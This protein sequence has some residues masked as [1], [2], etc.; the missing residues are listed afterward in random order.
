[1]L[2]ACTAAASSSPHAVMITVGPQTSPAD[3]A[4]HIR[5]TGLSAGQQATLQVS[6]TDAKDVH[7]L[8][9]AS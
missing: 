3:Q 4:V 9:S 5:V 6:S 7:W 1:M 2:S 8:A